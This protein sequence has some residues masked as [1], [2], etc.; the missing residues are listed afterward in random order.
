MKLAY[1]IVA[2]FLLF[3]LSNQQQLASGGQGS[4]ICLNPCMVTS[5]S[6]YCTDCDGDPDCVGYVQCAQQGITFEGCAY[7][8]SM[9][10]ENLLL[11]AEGCN[12]VTAPIGL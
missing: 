9:S 8:S 3:L 5:C 11:C 1:S 7:P 12:A 6:D 2:L 4:P 10:A